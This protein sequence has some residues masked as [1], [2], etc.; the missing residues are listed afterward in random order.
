M[1][2]CVPLM[3]VA[4]L[5]ADAVSA[6]QQARVPVRSVEAVRTGAAP[7][8]DGRLREDA[9]LTATAASGFVQ[10]RPAPGNPATEP[11]EVRILYDDAAI[12]IGV[13]NRDSRPDSI[14]GRL[15]RRDQPVQSDWFTVLVD[16]YHD[17]RTAFA[18][19]V[20]P[21]GVKRD[22]TIVGDEREDDNWDAVWEV[23]T[24]QDGEGWT[25]EYRIP[26]AQL[27]FRADAESLVWGI[28]FARLVARRDELSHWSPVD[29]TRTGV[30][31]QFGEIVGLR[32]LSPPRGLE[33]QPYTVARAT[34]AP[35]EPGNPFY[36]ATAVEASAGADIRYGIGSGL[37]LSATI[38]PDFGQVEADP[39]QVNLTAN[40]IRFA[41]RRPFFLEGTEI[42]DTDFPQVF[43]PRRIGAAPYGRVT[44]PSH[45]TDMP[46][47][48]TILGAAKLVGKT[49]G[50][51]SLGILDAVTAREHATWADTAEGRV[52]E[53]VVAPLTNFLAARAARDYNRGASAVGIIATAVHRE[54]QRSLSTPRASQA[55]VAG[56]DGRHRFGGGNF[57]IAG[58]ALGTRLEGSEQAIAAIQ[59]S[60]THGFNR[61]DADHLAYDSTR[62]SMDGYM[63]RGTVS[64]VGGGGWRVVAGGMLLSPAFN[65]NDMGFGPTSDRARQWTDFAY[66]DFTPGPLFRRWIVQFGQASAFTYGRELED[67]NA[68]VRVQGQRHD[69]SSVQVF[70]SRWGRTANTNILRGGG[71]LMEQGGTMV[72]LEYEGDARRAIRPIIEASV[73]HEDGTAGGGL[74]IEPSVA[75][76]PTSNIDV[77]IAATFESDANPAQYIGGFGSSG[78]TRY[79]VGHLNQRTAAATLRA[80]Y[81]LS[82]T[83][84]FQLYAQPFMSAG[85]YSRFRLVRDGRA[86]RFDDRFETLSSDQ[87]DTPDEEGV[88]A[89]DPDRD[90]VADFRFRNPDFNIK[91]LNSTAVLRWEYRPGSTLFVVWGHGRDHVT[92]DGR[93][94]FGRDASSLMRAQGTNVLM[95][96][97]SYWLG[98]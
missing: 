11:T 91:H 36:R 49:S 27:R 13:R 42:F 67:L 59:R 72:S 82:P 1:V 66:Q 45:F 90:G 80:D 94:R 60:F 55:Y 53:A 83:L 35:A 43:Y 58:T 63:M 56:V 12:Y 31:S 16:S 51:W 92:A 8:I 44:G 96:K 76:R 89:V 29:P 79:L 18:F 75:V 74:S 37:T 40:E 50:G 70:A 5:A 26:L 95:I 64:K 52:G 69:H 71:A 4:L 39:S 48:S 68:H 19:A 93:S 41:E 65:V 30:V 97:A 61:P 85:A 73:S 34:R 24:A 88:R 10:N 22:F 46:H 87:L 15:A 78:G 2:R 25:A 32:G 86:A 77:R 84:S 38:N 9:W 17:R 6:Q 7:E 3:L 33:V 28:N 20:N 14:V 47:Q 98:L 57:E 81:T 21:S 54:S 62:T 23:A